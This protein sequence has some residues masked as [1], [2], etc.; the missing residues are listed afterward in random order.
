MF[1]VRSSFW[2]ADFDLLK[3]DFEGV[4]EKIK[5]TP[6]EYDHSGPKGDNSPLPTNDKSVIG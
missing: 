3:K 6:S 1:V 5:A 2:S 4:L